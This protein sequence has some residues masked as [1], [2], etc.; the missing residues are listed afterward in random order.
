MKIPIYQ[1][2]AFADRVFAGN[3]AA[4]CPLREWLDDAVLQAVAQENNLSETAFF[5]PE[6]EGYHIR[7]F[8]PVAE[9]DLCGHATLG[10]AYLILHELEP[11]L[12]RVIFRSRSGIL[13]VHREGDTLAMDFPAQPPN[14]CDMPPAMPQALGMT[15]MEVLASEDYFVVLPNEED[16]AATKPDFIRLKELELR[17]IIVTAKGNQ[18]DFVSRFFAPKLGIDE[19]P[20]TGSAHC[21]LTPYWADRL[22]KSTLRAHQLSKR[23]GTLYCEDRGDRVVIA[24][25]AVKYL[26]G[27]ITI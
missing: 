15:P 22:G 12:N 13:S 5:V 8:T 18:A 1:I 20:V 25:K 19:D 3:P 24:G 21:A 7:W 10:T 23:G 2:D 26:E 4:V 17:G 16:V 6:D 27:H 11:S 9:V 14:P